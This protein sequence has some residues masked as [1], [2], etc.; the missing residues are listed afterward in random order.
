MTCICC[1]NPR[2]PPLKIYCEQCYI[3]FNSYIRLYGDDLRKYVNTK[4]C[5]KLPRFK[6]RKSYLDYYRFCKR[7]STFDDL[8]EY[9]CL[10]EHM[11][12]LKV[13][14]DRAK[15][16]KGFMVNQQNLCE[17]LNMLNYAYRNS[18]ENFKHEVEITLNQLFRF[19]LKKPLLPLW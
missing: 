2:N 13:S 17:A 16:I 8:P 19:E 5:V 9:V 11:I 7:F 10:R 4:Y 1:G 3:A 18:F 6:H 15:K 12:F 14:E